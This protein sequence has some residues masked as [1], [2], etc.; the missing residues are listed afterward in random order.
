MSSDLLFYSSKSYPRDFWNQ[1]LLDTSPL[2][3]HSIMYMSCQCMAP[4]TAT[5]GS[6]VRAELLSC[7][8]LSMKY[9]FQVPVND[10]YPLHDFKKKIAGLVF[11]THKWFQMVGNFWENRVKSSSKKKS[12]QGGSHVQGNVALHL[13]HNPVIGFEKEVI[14]IKNHIVGVWWYIFI[15]AS[16]RIITIW[17]GKLTMNEMRKYQQF[18]VNKHL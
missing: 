10:W 16:G 3:Y 9:I 1:D 12:T 2:P 18:E 8:G 14:A 4:C 7:N 17:S 13:D 11:Y 6:E 15:L 5:L